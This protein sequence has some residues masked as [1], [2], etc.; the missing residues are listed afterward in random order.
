MFQSK[1]I[2]TFEY[3]AI[4]GEEGCTCLGIPIHVMREVYNKDEIF[5]KTNK[6]LIE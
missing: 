1:G 4:S 3:D 5:K 6:K 2:P